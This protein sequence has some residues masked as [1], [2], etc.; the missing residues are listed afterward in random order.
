MPSACDQPEMLLVSNI[1]ASREDVNN[2]DRATDG[3]REVVVEQLI[4]SIELY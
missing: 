1:G 2:R 4:N 3:N